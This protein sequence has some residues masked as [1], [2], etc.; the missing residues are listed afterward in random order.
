MVEGTQD[1]KLFLEVLLDDAEAMSI[2]RETV[3]Y[4]VVTALF[5][6]SSDLIIQMKEESR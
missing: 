5:A 1:P 6:D 3:E 4:D 2:L